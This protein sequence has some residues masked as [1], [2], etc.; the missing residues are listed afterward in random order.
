MAASVKSELESIILSRGMNPVPWLAIYA[1]KDCLPDFKAN[2]V[3]AGIGMTMRLSIAITS[4][5]ARTNALNSI[6]RE[7]VLPKSGAKLAR[8]NAAIAAIETILGG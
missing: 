4:R 6:R 1:A 3:G 5:E 7:L 2:R 8:Y